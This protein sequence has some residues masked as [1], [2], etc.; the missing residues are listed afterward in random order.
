MLAPPHSL[1]WILW[2]WCGQRPAPP[3]S[4]QSPSC[5]GAD[6][7]LM[8]T[9][10]TRPFPRDGSAL[11]DAALKHLRAPLKRAVQPGRCRVLFSQQSERVKMHSGSVAPLASLVAPEMLSSG[12]FCATRDGDSVG[13]QSLLVDNQAPQYCANLGSSGFVTVKQV[14]GWQRVI[15]LRRPRKNFIDM[16]PG[17]GLPN[18]QGGAGQEGN[19]RW[20]SLPARLRWSLPDFNKTE[21]LERPTP[22]KP[23][24]A[25]VP[26]PTC[27]TS[28]SRSFRTPMCSWSRCS[29][30]RWLTPVIVMAA[31]TSSFLQSVHR[32]V[33]LGKCT[34]R[35]QGRSLMRGCKSGQT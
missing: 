14:K 28:R 9:N 26:V 12:L 34:A 27:T 35:L 30:S 3:H 15:V 13:R 17:F 32:V 24:N 18:E 29:R 8:P 19:G 7:R 21:Q 33:V 10:L 11:I 5:A 31:G 20:G 25:G 16:A 2:R 23:M 1:H 4:L 22:R 6:F